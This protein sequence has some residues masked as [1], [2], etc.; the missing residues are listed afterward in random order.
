MKAWLLKLATVLLI[1]IGLAGCAGTGAKF[2]SSPQNPQ[3]AQEPWPHSAN[4][5]ENV[6]S[7]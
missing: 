4:A 3:E 5:F 7:Y 2:A 6:R 1:G